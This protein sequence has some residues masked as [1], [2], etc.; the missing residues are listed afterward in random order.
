MDV[1]F[2]HLCPYETLKEL[3]NIVLK[4]RIEEILFIEIQ[5]FVVCF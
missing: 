4:L 2:N 3:L 1:Q 5:Y